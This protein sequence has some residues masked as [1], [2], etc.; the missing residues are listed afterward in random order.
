MEK[1]EFN[2]IF[3][4]LHLINLYIAANASADTPRQR[5][6]IRTIQK[7]AYH[8][9]CVTINETVYAFIKSFLPGF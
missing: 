1:K 2:L 9:P 6:L 3:I 5:L 4:K 7:G 8:T